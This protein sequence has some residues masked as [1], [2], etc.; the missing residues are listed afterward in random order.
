MSKKK[1]FKK[2]K[3]GS[4]TAMQKATLALNIANKLRRELRPAIKT[5]DISVS[6]SIDNTTLGTHQVS[7]VNDGELD[8]ER[9]G[10]DIRSKST[11]LKFTITKHATPATTIVRISYIKYESSAEPSAGGVYDGGLGINNMKN[12]DNKSKIHFYKD[13]YITLTTDNP[14]YQGTY[15]KKHNFVTQFTNNLG[16][17]RANNHLWFLYQ[18]D[19][20]SATAPSLTLESRYRFTNM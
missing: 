13:Q 1:T 19:Q 7:N 18:S 2:K 11:E 16:T 5:R 3:S 12:L 10:N 6:D 20:A 4:M 9:T 17:G 14:V 8:E 15:Y